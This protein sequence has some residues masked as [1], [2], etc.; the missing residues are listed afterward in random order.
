MTGAMSTRPAE[1]VVPPQAYSELQRLRDDI[2]TVL[3]SI[4]LANDPEVMASLEQ[5]E[6]NVA[7]GRTV[8]LREYLSRRD[9]TS[10]S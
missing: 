2:D 4:A 10:L 9:N 7:A 8:G 3:E 6:E 5:A 1:L